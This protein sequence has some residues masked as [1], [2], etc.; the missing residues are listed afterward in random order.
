MTKGKNPSGTTARVKKILFF[1]NDNAVLK[2]LW[3]TYK[4]IEMLGAENISP[5]I[6]PMKTDIKNPSVSTALLG[7]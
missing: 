2:T 5:T 4:K 6:V 1:L 3:T 7:L